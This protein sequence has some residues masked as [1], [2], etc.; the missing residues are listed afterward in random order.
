MGKRAAT[1]GA[2]TSGSKKAKV[3]TN[4]VKKVWPQ[5]SE[6]L[7][8][9]FDPFPAKIRCKLRYSTIVGLDPQVSTP[10]IN[11]FRANSIFD[12]DYSGAGHQPYGHDQ[13]QAL[14]NHYSV[15]SS[16][17]TMTPTNAQ[18]GIFGI[19]ISDDAVINT[20]YDTVRETKGT[21]MSTMQSNGLKKSV[22]NTFNQKQ[23]Y[24][25][26]PGITTGALFGGN[27]VEQTFFHCW[28]EAYAGEVNPG[29]TYF[30]ITITYTCTL[31]EPKDLGQS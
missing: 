21:K 8:P 19:S 27:P 28:N 23:I 18:N 24:G 5:S 7:G 29:V 17:I 25:K 1:T 2:I 3:K 6:G 20:N 11:L 31:W 10:G 9:M 30:L 14:Y 22:V 16:V 13:Y 4:Y 26:Q 12:P 15:D